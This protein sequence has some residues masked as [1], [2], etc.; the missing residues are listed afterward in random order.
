MEV[1][2]YVAGW[3]YERGCFFFVRN[4]YVFLVPTFELEIFRDDYNS[5]FEMI[6]ETKYTGID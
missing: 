2:F 1:D 6:Y 3:I 4:S 5:C